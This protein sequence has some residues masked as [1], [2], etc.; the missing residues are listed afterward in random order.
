MCVGYVI[1]PLL[2]IVEHGIPVVGFLSHM[3]RIQSPRHKEY[4]EFIWREFA[5]N[6]PRQLKGRQTSNNQS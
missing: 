6:M 2:S 4:S 1:E 5:S 3:R